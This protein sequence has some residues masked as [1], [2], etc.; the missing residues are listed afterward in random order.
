LD[1]HVPGRFVLLGCQMVKSRYGMK[2]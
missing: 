1:S 2:Q